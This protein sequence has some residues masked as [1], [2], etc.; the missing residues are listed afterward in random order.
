MSSGTILGTCVYL[1]RDGSW[2][3]LLTNKKKHDVNHGKWIG[4]GGKTLAQ[5]S[6][7]DCAVRE[8]REE[9]GLKALSLEFHGFVYFTYEHQKSE[10]IAV[11]SCRSF[12]GELTDCTEGTLKWIP[13]EQIM[14]LELWEGDRIFL[15]RM[16]S[17]AHA[18][19]CYELRYDESGRMTAAEE[20][21]TEHE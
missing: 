18:R 10:K 5:E 7:H 14:K 3:M 4:V 15:E 17:D 12:S 8:L 20:R 11:Y 2:L 19:F 9:T 16:L 13:Q 21:M 1:T 6:F